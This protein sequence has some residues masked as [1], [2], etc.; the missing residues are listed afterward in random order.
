MLHATR[1]LHT[2][3]C[4]TLTGDTS[5]HVASILLHLLH[6]HAAAPTPMLSAR[7]SSAY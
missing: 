6:L 3:G 2:G 4:L 7:V 5:A 1:M